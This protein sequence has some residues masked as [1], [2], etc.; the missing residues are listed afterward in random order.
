[1]FVT[2]PRVSP[3]S[4]SLAQN[5]FRQEMTQTWWPP[6]INSRL[7][8]KVVVPVGSELLRVKK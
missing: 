3:I 7:L 6:F 5:S 8:L 1:M 2:L 4:V